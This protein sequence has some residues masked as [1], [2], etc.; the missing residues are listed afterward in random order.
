MFGVYYSLCFMFIIIL[1]VLITYWRGQ[2]REYPK[3]KY[4][5][6][7]KYYAQ[8][9]ERWYCG[10][11]FVSYSFSDGDSEEFC[12]WPVGFYRY[13]LR[14]YLIK[15]ANRRKE[16]AESLQ[17]MLDDINKTEAQNGSR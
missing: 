1:T 14:N 11:S 8:N 5:D 6:F 9:P 7:R 4:R 17:R 12:F 13:R 3:I 15:M 2:S 10:C 16:N